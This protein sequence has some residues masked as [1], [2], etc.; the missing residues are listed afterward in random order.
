MNKSQIPWPQFNTVPKIVPKSVP[1]KP[2]KSYIKKFEN[3][4]FRHFRDCIES[5]P[6]SQSQRPSSPIPTQSRDRN[7]NSNRGHK[8]RISIGRVCVWHRGEASL[9][10]GMGPGHDE[11]NFPLY[12]FSKCSFVIIPEF[13]HDDDET[14][15]VG[16]LVGISIPLLP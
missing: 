1:K 13:C 8:I 4:K 12:V 15:V 3:Q 9:R 7:C 14:V 10:E 11:P 6:R 2:S 16:W 5:R